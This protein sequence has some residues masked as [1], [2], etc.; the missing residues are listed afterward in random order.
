M[1]NPKCPRCQQDISVDD[2]I[3]LEGDQV[4]H[5]DCRRP[6]DLSHEERALLF[7][8]CF[9]HAVADCGPCG[10][11]HLRHELASDLIGHRTLLC[12]TCRTDLT[13]A[14]RAHLY[15]CATLP[16][17]IRLKARELREATGKLVKRS[18]EI[19]ARADVLMREAEAAVGMQS[20]LLAEVRAALAE[21]RATMQRLAT[22]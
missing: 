8:Y 5:V 10:K 11:S 18:Q 4:A 6:R 16:A 14:I 9:D 22:Q 3:T 12:P 19:V 21:L 17:E 15:H 20:A 1:A 7:N 2:T 13:G